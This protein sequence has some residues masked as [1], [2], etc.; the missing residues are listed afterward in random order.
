MVYWK[1]CRL[2]YETELSLAA[3]KARSMGSV[4]AVQTAVDSVQMMDLASYLVTRL[5]CFVLCY[6]SYKV[7]SQYLQNKIQQTLLICTTLYMTYQDS[8]Q[9]INL[10]TGSEIALG[11]TLGY[12]LSRNEQVYVSSDQS[13]NKKHY[14]YR[15]K[16]F[17]LLTGQTRR[18]ECSW[19]KSWQLTESRE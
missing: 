11:S 18:H 9:E 8:M 7:E 16:H 4:K 19:Q 13:K 1:A 15:N 10:E 5:Y 6:I 3:L 17:I 2:G 12:R 14:T